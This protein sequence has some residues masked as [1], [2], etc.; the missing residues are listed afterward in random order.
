MNREQFIQTWFSPEGNPDPSALR[1]MAER[2]GLLWNHYQVLLVH[3]NGYDESVEGADDRLKNQL[4][5][6]FEENGH[7][8]VFSMHGQLGVLMHT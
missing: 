7:G 3:R 4:I 5:K 1:N 6:A 2:S 8:A